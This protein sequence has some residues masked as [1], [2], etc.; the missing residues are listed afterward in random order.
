MMKALVQEGSGS[1][2]VLQLREIPRP[3]PDDDR[4]LL[5]VHAASVNAADWHT[6]HGGFMVA[7]VGTLMRQPKRT[8]TVLGGDVAGVIVEVGK[9]VTDLKPGDE[10]FGTGRGTFAEYTVSR[11]GALAR[12]PARLSFEQAGAIGVAGSTALQGLRDQGHLREGQRVL[13]FG[14]GGGVGTFAVQIAKALGAHVTAVTHT[15]SVEAV[16]SLAPDEV[17]DYTKED[18]TRR[19]DR[20][21]IVFDVA[22]TRPLGSLLR[23]LTASGTLVI[24]GAAKRGG[25]I[26]IFGRIVKAKVLASVF[27][28]RIT[29]YV[30]QIRHDDLVVLAKM[31]EGG[32]L[33]PL[34]DRTFP[35]TEARE[36]VRY[37]GTGEAR[38]KVVI[39]VA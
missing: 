39:T 22:G 37:L 28:K 11:P 18:V 6:V 29:F 16:R 15:R 34:I 21:D 2:D 4:V 10:V 25:M 23:L 32:T 14:A 26:G 27:K 31:A 3:A 7:V 33:C 36:A 17:I 19:A 9:N 20:Y 12:K 35:L 8:E 5:K 1:A 24:A 30:A 38:A 13:V